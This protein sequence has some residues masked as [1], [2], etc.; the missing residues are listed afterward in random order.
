MVM[1]NMLKAAYYIHHALDGSPRRC[2]QGII[3]GGSTL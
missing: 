3:K 1:Q 2:F